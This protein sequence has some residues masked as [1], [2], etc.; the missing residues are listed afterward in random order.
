MHD[1][2][3]ER[4]VLRN[5]SAHD[6]ADLLAYLHQPTASCFFS[7]ALPDLQAAQAE[8]TKRAAGDGDIAIC[9]KTS[10]ALIGDLF[11]APDD[12]PFSDRTFSIGWNFNPRFGGQG[13]A[14]EAAQA[15][16]SHLFNHRQARRLYAYVE[17]TNHP[18]A[19]L[20]E[21][22]GMRLEGVFKEFVTFH[23]DARGQPV[24][25]D[26]MQYALLRSEWLRR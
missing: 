14:A 25:E 9:L 8:A 17:T 2:E 26:T 11:V 22:L 19:R 23:N 18:S 4:L 10:G 5:F 15:L 1:I 24:Y 6:A 7:L 16:L 21:K 13:Y 3:T 20:C 12:D